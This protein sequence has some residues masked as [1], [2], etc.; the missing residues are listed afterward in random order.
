MIRVNVVTEGQS[1]MWFVKKALSKYFG[2]SPLVDARS[3]MT[4]RNSKTNYE[5]RGGLLKY[6]HAKSDIL[7][8][9]KEDTT[10]YVTT[11]FD[12]FRLPFDFPGYEKA[13]ACQDHRESVRILEEKLREDIAE[14]SGEDAKQRFVPYIQLHEFEAL[15]FTDIRVLEYDYLEDIAQIE[16]LYRDT[17][18]ILPEDINHGAETAPSKRLL[19]TINYKKG[20]SSWELLDMIG[21]PV[22][23]KKCFHFS[24]WIGTLEKLTEL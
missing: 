17:E 10:A 8:W 15:L 7:R 13:A 2:S 12:F 23:R 11:M 1:E 9:L 19:H 18:G 4:G 24:E 21:I 16:Q 22:I 3:V 14:N 5:Y 20:E 6:Q